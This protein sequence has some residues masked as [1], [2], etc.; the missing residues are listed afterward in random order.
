[1]AD[2]RLARRQRMLRYRY[3]EGFDRL[4]IVAFALFALAFGLLWL[5]VN[6]PFALPAEGTPQAAAIAAELETACRDDLE[7]ALV[8]LCHERVL[9]A[10]R[11]DFYSEQLAL[12]TNGWLYGLL[13]LAVVAGAAWPVGCWVQR[14]FRK[15]RPA[16]AGN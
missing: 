14:G 12:D 16:A 2:R 15:A 9:G 8:M 13:L 4:A 3:K 6:E 1:M 11:W 5:F 7:R 10:Y